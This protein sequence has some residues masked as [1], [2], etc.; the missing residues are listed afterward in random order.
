M[1]YTRGCGFPDGEKKKKKKNYIQ[2]NCN[3]GS[4]FTYRLRLL[5]HKIYLQVENNITIKLVV[6]RLVDP[7]CDAGE[8]LVEAHRHRTLIHSLVTP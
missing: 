4:I 3:Y 2:N 7:L 8:P 5:N 1:W 6:H